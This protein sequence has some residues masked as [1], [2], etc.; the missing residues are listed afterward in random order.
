MPGCSKCSKKKKKI[1]AIR[2]RL[3]NFMRELLKKYIVEKKYNLHESNEF[4]RVTD[5]KIESNNRSDMRF[6]VSS[7]F[8]LSF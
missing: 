8:F 4:L 3:K 6:N 7:N 2:A 1:S 5:A